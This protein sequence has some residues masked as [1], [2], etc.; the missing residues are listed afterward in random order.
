[1]IHITKENIVECKVDA[2]VNAANTYLVGGGGVDGAIHRAAG[3]ELY[4]ACEKIGRCAVGK[5]VVTPGFKLNAKYIIHTVGPFYSEYE[6]KECAESLSSCYIS[7]LEIAKQKN[8]HSIAF[9]CISSGIYGY[10][11]EESSFIAFNTVKNWLD[12]NAGY[13]IEVYLVC[14]KDSEYE[15]YENVVESFTQEDSDDEA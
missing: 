10:P 12:E 7:C 4:E 11:I 15:A 14:Y 5:A 3:P 13:D 9:P 2:I 8:V 6:K 1:M